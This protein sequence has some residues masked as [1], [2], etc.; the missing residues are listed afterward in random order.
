[1][2]DNMTVSTRPQTPQSTLA[3]SGSRHERTVVFGG[4]GPRI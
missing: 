1:M 2:E 3:L 4:W